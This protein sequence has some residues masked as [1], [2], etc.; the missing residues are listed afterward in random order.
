MNLSERHYKELSEGSGISDEII[1]T[2]GFY[3]EYDG[4]QLAY[5]GFGGD[6]RRAPALVL[7]MHG[8]NDSYP[9]RYQI[10]PDEPRVVE[11]VAKKYEW[12]FKLSPV[13]ACPPVPVVRDALASPNE[14]F[15]ITEG[16]KKAA[17]A[18]TQGVAC[19]CLNGVWNWKAKTSN[20]IKTTIAELD[21]IHFQ[22]RPVYIAFDSDMMQKEGVYWAMARLTAQLV[23]R[24]AKVKYCF[25]P[26]EYGKGLDDYFVNGGTVPQ[27]FELAT[28]LMPQALGRR[29][30]F[31]DA[32]MAYRV[33]DVYGD[34]MVF[35]NRNNMWYVWADNRWIRDN[36]GSFIRKR[37]L[38]HTDLIRDEV[39]AMKEDKA[40]IARHLE[41]ADEYGDA[42]K[43]R[44][45]ATLLQSIMAEEETGFDEKPE[46]LNCTNGTLDLET[47]DFYPHKPSDRLTVMC[48]TPWDE[49][50]EAPLWES[51]MEERFPDVKTRE[52]VQRMCG[53]FVTGRSAEKAFFIIRGEKDCG[54][55]VFVESLQKML[56]G[57]AN[58]VDKN[59]LTKS[60]GGDAKQLE[61]A[62]ELV[63]KR[64]VYV[65]ESSATDKLDEAYIKEITGG[66]ATLKFRKLYEQ[67]NQAAA[68]FTLILATNFKP[69]ITG[70]DDAVWRR[71]YLIE[72]GES[73][74]RDKQIAGFGDILLEKEAAGILR[75]CVKGYQSWKKHG[76][77]LPEEIADWTREYREENDPIGKFLVENYEIHADIP[78]Y[79]FPG[80]IALHYDA[81]IAE[82]EMEGI[83]ARGK[84]AVG[85]I[86]RQRWP[87]VNDGPRRAGGRA[88][89]HIRRIT[90][91]REDEDDLVEGTDYVH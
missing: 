55:T 28:A 47:M 50:A 15:V 14:P 24:G 39:G 77:A 31:N 45:A 74:P 2:I 41:F 53:L 62:V 40:S 65:D 27:L 19:L 52:F 90:P 67:A 81:W 4:R 71:C 76:L 49:N 86:I 70:Q 44:G 72:F 43:I 60:K 80:D 64:M 37:I 36:P 59:T 84:A 42:S 78:G 17:S 35:D 13:L 33:A 20:G 54:K 32:G 22:G 87:I 88:L 10:K 1:E 23:R 29:Y 5:L 79:L 12:P 21:T 16:L 8:P 73:I 91:F 48:P 69:R 30:T 63:G 7:P 6:Q 11:G 85:K 68:E 56:G 66:D 26:E 58:K 82:N 75:W 34:E 25:L 57:Y 89:Y 61:R 9:V 83:K 51:F 38:D 3:T 18:A 46:L